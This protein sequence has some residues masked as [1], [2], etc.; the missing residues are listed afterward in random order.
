MELI[1]SNPLLDYAFTDI[2]ENYSIEAYSEIKGSSLELLSSRIKNITYALVQ[3]FNYTEV[4]FNFENHIF[5]L[6]YN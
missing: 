4:Q 1:S 5:N 6:K 2:R 3:R